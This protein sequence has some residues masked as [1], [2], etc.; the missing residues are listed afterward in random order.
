MTDRILGQPTNLTTVSGQVVTIANGELH[1]PIILDYFS[2]AGGHYL[3][4]VTR[5]AAAEITNIT[6]TGTE[7]GD[8]EFEFTV[9]GDISAWVSGDQITPQRQATLYQYATFAAMEAD[10][11][12]DNDQALVW[13]NTT[14]GRESWADEQNGGVVGDAYPTYGVWG[15]L[16]AQRITF[17]NFTGFRKT[18]SWGGNASMEN[19]TATGSKDLSAPTIYC[20]FTSA[21]ERMNLR[22]L[23][24][25]GGRY[26]YSIAG[27]N[28][29]NCIGIGGGEIE[30][31]AGCFTGGA[32]TAY[33]CLGVF[34]V[35]GFYSHNSAGDPLIIGCA[36]ILNTMHG[37]YS[38][39]GEYDDYYDSGCTLNTTDSTWV[40]FNAGTTGIDLANAKLAR[41]NSNG[42]FPLSFMIGEGSTW[43]GA[44]PTYAVSSNKYD[45]VG[46]DRLQDGS[47]Q[48][49]G[50]YEVGTL[51]TSEEIAQS[52]AA[53]GL[54]ITDAG[55]GATWR[56]Q[57]AG[58]SE[59]AAIY[60]Y[61]H[62]GDA[63]VAITDADGYTKDLTAEQELY[64]EAL[65]AGKTLSVR[66]PAASGVT[67]PVL[68]NPSPSAASITSGTPGD[69]QV[70][71]AVAAAAGTD[72]I[73]GRSMKWPSGSFTEESESVKRTGS[74]DLVIP[75]LDN[76][77]TY[78]LAIY[79]KSGNLTS[80]WCV[81]AAIPDDD[82]VG[83]II[84]LYVN[85][86]VATLQTAAIFRYVIRSIQDI[87]AGGVPGCVVTGKS[88][89]ENDTNG[90]NL[91]VNK[92]VTI[93]LK[94]HIKDNKNPDLTMAKLQDQV[95]AVFRDYVFTTVPGHYD[96]TAS[97]GELE[98]VDD[99]TLFTHKSTIRLECQC[100]VLRTGG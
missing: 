48:S 52:T 95:M 54:T 58:V 70:S 99:K 21:A 19:F 9:S 49:I 11:V 34:G 33:Q 92:T 12:A 42:A 51:A 93:E 43:D 75:S 45:I 78:L 6:I 27:A 17:C 30:R 60:L 65:E 76:R 77:S 14:V 16:A 5:S 38:W 31:G 2:G 50:P 87:P 72:V 89:P 15:M 94:L 85:E 4:N 74:G 67:V 66:Y 71:L 83:S 7:P 18:V 46:R 68:A 79:A 90:T 20:N 40:P 41:N 98:D 23:V 100:R 61:N 56:V 25:L 80:D 36:A 86:A 82:A 29:R 8:W 64:C 39:G 44:G 10:G 88:H 69:G 1:R 53:S 55:D 63:L 57:A 97:P 59:G 73:Y 32:Y 22:D 84:G 37:F 81:L 13:Y 26:C 62:S 91:S 96:M 3:Y 28:L 35:N 24:A 47:Q